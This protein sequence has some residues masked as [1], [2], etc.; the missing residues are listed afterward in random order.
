MKG[1]AF[2]PAP[3]IRFEMGRLKGIISVS[4]A[5]TGDTDALP[6]GR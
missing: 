1:A 5:R 2:T 3:V 6:G 4:I